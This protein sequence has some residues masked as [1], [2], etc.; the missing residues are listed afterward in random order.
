M[1]LAADINMSTEQL[2]DQWVRQ[3]RYA[4]DTQRKLLRAEQALVD[5]ANEVGRRLAPHNM[6]IGVTVGVW[7]RVDS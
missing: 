2:C 1:R 7:T 4:L 5:C 6:L 3:M